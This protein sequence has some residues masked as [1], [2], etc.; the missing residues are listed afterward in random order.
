[1]KI[2]Y[3]VTS[4]PKVC[5]KNDA[6]TIPYKYQTSLTSMKN[7]PPEEVK[8]PNKTYLFKVNIEDLPESPLHGPAFGL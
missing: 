8:V 1:M 3:L 2:E 6:E 4:Q 5:D 7:P